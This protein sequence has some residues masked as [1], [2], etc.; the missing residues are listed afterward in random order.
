MN[1]GQL[2]DVVRDRYGDGL[3]AKQAVEAVL[4]VM[5]RELTSEGGGRV[6]VTGF[7]TLEVRTRAARYARNPKNG[8]RVRVPA[9]RWVRFIAGRNL[10]AL[11][12]GEKKLPDQESAIKKAPKG[13][14]TSP[15]G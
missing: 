14:V 6:S 1:K 13:S 9:I 3:S 15:K 5:V 2:I 12:N 10:T 11:V 4:D 7:G 8:E